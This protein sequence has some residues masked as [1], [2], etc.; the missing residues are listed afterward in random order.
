VLLLKKFHRSYTAR[1]P[2]VAQQKT[3]KSKKQRRT[4]GEKLNKTK[5]TK[6]ILKYGKFSTE[7]EKVNEKQINKM[8]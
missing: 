8:T 1:E 7:K 6:L 3:K 5:Q 4:K 2:Y